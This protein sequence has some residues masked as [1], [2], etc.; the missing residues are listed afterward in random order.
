MD[1]DFT[2]SDH[3][4]TDRV[5]KYGYTHF[6]I[7]TGPRNAAGG[8]TFHCSLLLESVGLCD[9]HPVEL[10]VEVQLARPCAAHPA[11][12]T[13]RGEWRPCTAIV[14][15]K[16][17]ALQLAA[18][19]G[20]RRLHELGVLDGHLD[21]VGRREARRHLH[22]RH[23]DGVPRGGRRENQR[24]LH[25][26][27][28]FVRWLPRCLMSADAEWW[29]RPW[30]HLIKLGGV[31]LSVG[32]LLP[33]SVTLAFDV[34]ILPGARP[35]VLT[36]LRQLSLSRKQ[37]DDV[38]SWLVGSQELLRSAGDIV[39]PLHSSLQAPAQ[40]MAFDRQRGVWTPQPRDA[41]ASD[42]AASDA[43]AG[44]ADAPAPSAACNRWQ[45]AIDSGRKTAPELGLV[46]FETLFGVGA[47]A[48]AVGAVGAMPPS[49]LVVVV[50]DLDDTLWQGRCEDLD[51]GD[52]V[53][54]ELG[55]TVGVYVQNEDGDPDPER[56]IL[57]LH[58][59]VPLLFEALREARHLAGGRLK[60]ALASLSP[61][62]ER[63]RAVLH[64]CGLHST[65]TEGVDGV[66][67]AADFV[68]I[69]HAQG[70]DDKTAHL[71]AACM[72]LGAQ[73][74]QL[75]LYDDS[76]RCVHAAREQ[77]CVA[78]EI[79]PAQGLTADALLR[80][81]EQMAV[82]R[83]GGVAGG[84]ANG[85][86]GGV[87]AMQ[88]ENGDGASRVDAPAGG[89]PLTKEV[90]P[91]HIA[92][93]QCASCTLRRSACE[94]RCA[95]CKEKRRK[96]FQAH[97][98]K[99]EQK[100]ARSRAGSKAVALANL[101]APPGCWLA[102]PL[103][104]TGT[105]SAF[106]S[107]SSAAVDADA[108]TDAAAASSRELDWDFMQL[109]TRLFAT[110]DWPTLEQSDGPLVQLESH[111]DGSGGGNLRM[112]A[113][114][115]HKPMCSREIMLTDVSIDGPG[116]D[117]TVSGCYQKR[118]RGVKTLREFSKEDGRWVNRESKQQHFDRD[119]VRAILTLIRILRLP[120]L[121]PSPL[122]LTPSPR[123]NPN[124]SLP[125]LAGA[126]HPAAFFGR[127]RAH[128][129]AA[130][131]LAPRARCLAAR[132]DDSSGR[133]RQRPGRQSHRRRRRCR[134]H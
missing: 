32:L 37:R 36:P 68:Q 116:E 59:E 86:A 75:L 61:A 125:Y 80:G 22:S 104:L 55:G 90:M 26:E 10:L 7:E 47:A 9:A 129:A 79:D 31:E 23:M 127:R 128:L 35:C 110:C 5:D 102:A 28:P 113:L 18:L 21:V 44:D 41:A 46:I 133:A 3:H 124:R 134:R 103:K 105:G 6:L 99:E 78:V 49:P 107:S 121:P 27:D 62:E 15:S 108:D 88:I 119:E 122:A 25:T 77:G 69:G 29:T 115:G 58:E 70:A 24:L 111:G 132:D 94:K 82:R 51:E 130:H 56:G 93:I 101:P 97:Q 19:D 42:A 2:A 17:E 95:A 96:E 52:L 89:A 60:L 16:A 63:A 64:A 65:S 71:E 84:A 120:R 87:A 54:S 106:P 117:A 109:A 66:E 11:G 38:T 50:L 40:L 131:P 30:L 73:P 92:A 4:F 112:C 72:A 123:P 81:L 126:R 118:G 13:V 48:T 53:C 100:A 114:A 98:G 85:A 34:G 67:G 57:A 14:S 12:L 33:A 1:L 43:A 91:P 74:E 45:A 39:E 83:A 8:S 76:Q 20:C